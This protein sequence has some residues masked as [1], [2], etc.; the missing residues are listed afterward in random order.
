GTGDAESGHGHPDRPGGGLA[1]ARVRGLAWL[2]EPAEQPQTRAP[3]AE[4]RAEAVVSESLYKTRRRAERDDVAAAS[5]G[6]HGEFLETANWSPARPRHGVPLGWQRLR[7]EEW[8]GEV[9]RDWAP[10]GFRAH[11]PAAVRP[12][13]RSVPGGLQPEGR[14]GPMIA[15]TYS[16]A[17]RA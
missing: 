11:T 16:G 10:S 6:P 15:G 12:L 2:E 5:G 1:E 7:S 13:D 8:T 3:S 17:E 14:D 4:G 9:R